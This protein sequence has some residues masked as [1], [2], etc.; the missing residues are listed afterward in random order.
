MKK[1]IFVISTLILFAACSEKTTTAVVDTETKPDQSLA[2]AP[3][4]EIG[5]G[6]TIFE[7]KCTTCHEAKVI[8]D[9]KV[10]KWPKLLTNM[11]KRAE[12]SE[13]DESLVESYINWEL[14]N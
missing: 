11:A 14:S 2:M 13:A 5:Q 6:K 4:A 1:S 12:L 9:Y 10:E 3:T 7:S 8:D